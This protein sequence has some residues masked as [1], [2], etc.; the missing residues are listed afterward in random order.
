MSDLQGTASDA[1]MK[2]QIT[3]AA[4]GAVEDYELILTPL[5]IVQETEGDQPEKDSQ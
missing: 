1:R 3:R 5:P 2:I 4:T